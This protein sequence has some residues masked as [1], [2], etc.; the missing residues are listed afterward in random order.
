MVLHNW[1]WC[2]IFAW[3]VYAHEGSSETRLL[4]PSGNVFLLVFESEWD[5][6][7]VV[8]DTLVGIDSLSQGMPQRKMARFSTSL[9]FIIALLPRTPRLLFDMLLTMQS[10]VVRPSIIVNS[11]LFQEL[12][13]YTHQLVTMPRINALETRLLVFFFKYIKP[14][15]A[16]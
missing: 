4:H 1:E 10:I 12:L 5:K 2:F 15:K 6:V 16:Q 14:I 9:I 11:I 8:V 13:Q 3:F 7:A